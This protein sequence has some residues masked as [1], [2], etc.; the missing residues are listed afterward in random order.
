[1]TAG[2]NLG[3]P[4]EAQFRE[5]VN[6]HLDSIK[7]QT[8]RIQIAFFGGNFTGMNKDEQ[9]GLL[10]YAGQF[11]KKGLV[12]SI[13]IST[14]PD[15]IDTESLDRLKTFNVATVEIGAQSMVDEV[16]NLAGRGHSADDVTKAMKML[17]EWG[18]E[19]GIHLMAGL[20]GDNPSHF[21]FSV[22]KI[23]ALKPDTV[24]IHPTIVFADTRLERDYRNGAYI[25]MNL[26][27]AIDICK[28]ALNRFDEARIP[29][30]RLGL[31]TTREMDAPGCIIAGPYHPAFRSLV[32]ESFFF[33][34]A[35]SLLQTERVKNKV[36]TFIVSPKDVS[37][38]RGQ[39][40][41]NMRKIKACFDLAEIKLLT[42]PHQPR[43][44]L[45][46]KSENK[47]QARRKI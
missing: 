18:F 2:I 29:V 17:K 34:M 30:I 21:K 45:N 39:K 9:I 13:R 46:I 6:R 27:E 32:E 37:S 3:T 44:S 47:D 35:F 38:F 12:N 19:T 42:D 14:R 8:E 28:Y 23:I 20:P 41:G 24:R 36:V 40:N 33:D 10:E 5:T 7:K 43:R 25:P 1:M 26:T 31:Q 11:I 16:L 4:S 22:E 15:Y